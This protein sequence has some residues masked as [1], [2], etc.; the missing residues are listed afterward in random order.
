MLVSCVAQLGARAESRRVEIKLPPGA[1]TKITNCGSG[2]FLF[3]K[4]LEEILQKKIMVAKE[5]FW[6]LLQ[7]SSY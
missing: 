6:K 3:V 5:F 2:S 4:R 7:F 1:G